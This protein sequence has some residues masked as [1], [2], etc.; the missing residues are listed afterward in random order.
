MTVS[1]DL[2]ADGNCAMHAAMY[3]FSL[4]LFC[5]PDASHGA[6]RDFTL[7]LGILGMKSFWI[8]MLIS[9]NM[10]HGNEH[11]R[12][13]RYW[14]L[15]KAMS[16]YYSTQDPRTAVLFQD[17]VKQMRKELERSG[18]TFP[19]EKDIDVEV[20]EYMKAQA[21]FQKKDRKCS[22]ARFLA[23][24]SRPSELVK[25]WA[26]D[27]FQRQYVAI[28]C[29]YLR[30]KKFA[31]AVSI[32][33]GPGSGELVGE[34]GS[35]TSPKVL[36]IAD[37]SLRDSCANVVSVSVL[38]LSR[39]E[40]KRMCN[41]ILAPAKVLK[42]WEGQAN[43]RLRSADECEMW[44]AD[45]ATGQFMAHLNEMTAALMDPQ[46]LDECGFTL[47]PAGDDDEHNLK[48]LIEAEFADMLGRATFCTIGLRIRR[49]L[50]Y[51]AGWP[52]AF[53]A[54]IKRDDVWDR[55]CVDRFSRDK[56]NYDLLLAIATPSDADVKVLKSH[57]FQTL[58]VDQY[59]HA[60]RETMNVVTPD[61][62]AITSSKLRGPLQ[63][64]LIEEI[65]GV[66]KNRGRAK[67]STT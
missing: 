32:S 11:H 34:G 50:F 65:N 20:F 64:E 15:R 4:N 35:H 66:M 3:M 21:P 10:P 60:F 7:L 36:D 63:T 26:Q 57:Q 12:D 37:R 55:R 19:R 56:R 61:I 13:G 46:T 48:Y 33:L 17:N 62:R 27:R 25:E 28:E 38:M 1:M 54:V 30:G 29:D 59:V 58:A 39:D 43:K 31:G 16:H 41:V 42:R 14:Q 40:H 9:W 22:F 2:G 45:Q 23:A 52:H 18:V 24:V 49:G 51:M 6:N 5:W 67:Q 44:A 8:M 47:H 53:A